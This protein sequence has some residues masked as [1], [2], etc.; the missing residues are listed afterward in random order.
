MKSHTDIY[1]IGKQGNFI[2]VLWFCLWC[3]FVFRS[4]VCNAQEEQQAFEPIKIQRFDKALFTFITTESEQS[5][6]HLLETY[7]KMLDVLGMGVLNQKSHKEEV[8][9][10]RVK[11]YY[12]EP[13]LRS[14]Y[15]DALSEYDTMTDIES[16][17]S[18]GLAQLKQFFPQIQMPTV[19]AHV[20]GLHQNVLTAEGV[21]SLS[22]DKYIGEGYK[23][24]SEFFYETQRRKMQ[25]SFAALDYLAGWLMSEFPFTGNQKILLDRMIY[26]G[27]VKYVLS[28]VYPNKEEHELFAY[29]PAELAWCENNEEL[30]W[31][32]IIDQK[33]LFTADEQTT[34]K[35]MMER[36]CKFIHPNTPSNIGA[37]IGLQIV[38]DY[39]EEDSTKLLSLFQKTA[40]EVLMDSNY[41]P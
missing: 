26:D 7:P 25:R 18:L 28:L 34:M 29:T 13:T 5:K 8:F 3:L 1:I 9:F 31:K 33:N 6:A 23:L 36:P 22:I 20:S 16:E 32:Y 39:C 37:W 10:E 17:L 19:Y 11:S 2:R 27:A 14:L 35:Y 40:Q 38:K 30:I 21:L 4:F 24:Y 41:Q 15:Q 12:G